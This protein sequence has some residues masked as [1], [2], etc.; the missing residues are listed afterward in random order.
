LAYE[1]LFEINY[2]AISMK[3]K[4][5]EQTR[6]RAMSLKLDPEIVKYVLTKLPFDLTDHQKIAL[7]QVLKDMERDH[8]MQRLLE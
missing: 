5:F 1:E 6:G 3:Y 2:R 4:S 7:F 8:A